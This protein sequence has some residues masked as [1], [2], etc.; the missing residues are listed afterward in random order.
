MNRRRRP[1]ERAG[2][3]VSERRAGLENVDCRASFGALSTAVTCVLSMRYGSVV[4]VTEGRK[5]GRKG[6]KGT[7]YPVRVATRFTDDDW[8][9]FDKVAD[10]AGY[11]DARVVREAALLGQ[12]A[13]RERV[14]FARHRRAAAL[15]RFGRA[16]VGH[17][18]VA[19]I[20]VP[21]SAS[22]EEC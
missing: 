18:C 1:S 9:G 11:S 2:R 16:S 10:L 5:S 4:R 15:W 20:W 12:P 14:R 3:N 8:A 19:G 6:S 13:L 17:S 21:R 7:R 22:G